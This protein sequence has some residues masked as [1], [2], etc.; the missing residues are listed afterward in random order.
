[1]ADEVVVIDDGSATPLPAI[2]SPTVSVYRQEHRGISAAL[3]FGR[4][5]T[6]A[7]HLSWLSCGDTISRDK[8]GRS[9]AFMRDTDARAVFHNYHD[10][11]TRTLVM[12]RP[13]WKQKVWRDNQF[14]LGMC[15]LEAQVWDAVDGFDEELEWCLDWDFACK[16][17]DYCGWHHLNECLGMAGEYVDGHT[18]RAKRDE[19]LN[20]QRNACRAKVSRRWR[21]HGKVCQR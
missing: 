19:C 17:Q 3:N 15:L 6:D 10:V 7:S 5:H 12:P 11:K 14:C 2:Y 21:Y 16:V 18:E 8:L 9:L 1:M 20:A 4:A 13:D